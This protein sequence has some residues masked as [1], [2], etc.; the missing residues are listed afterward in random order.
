[1]KDDFLCTRP[2]EHRKV[3]GSCLPGAHSVVGADRHVNEELGWH[4]LNARIEVQVP[5]RCSEPGGGVCG[6]AASGKTSPRKGHVLSVLTF[7]EE[8]QGGCYRAKQNH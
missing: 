1:M 2:C 4:M 6:R 3:L 8:L 7:K 5:T